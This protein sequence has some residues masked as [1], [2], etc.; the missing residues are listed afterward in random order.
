MKNLSFLNRSTLIYLFSST[1][2]FNISKAQLGVSSGSVSHTVSNGLSSANESGFLNENTIIVEDFMNYHKHQ[3]KIPKKNEVA[4]SIDYDNTIL[5]SDD[6]F[7]LQ[8]GLA[9]QNVSARE[10]SNKANVSLVI[11]NSGSM[12]GGKLEKV[13]TALKVF[14][15]GLKPEDLIS[16]VKFDDTANLVL[17]SSKIKDV[18][19][20]LDAIIESIYPSGSTNI[21]SGMMMGYSEA[22]KH[23]TKDY[24]SKVILLT[25]GMTNSGITDPETILKQSKEFNDKG[26]DIST[27]G[28]GQQLDFDLLRRIAT[29][30]RGSNYFI[31]DVEEDIQKTFK[32]ELESLLYNIGKKPK[33]TI[34]LPEG[35][36]IKTFYGYQPKYI[37][38]HE[39][40]VELENL[41][42]GQ[43]QIFLME[44]EKN[45][46]ENSSIT[47]SLV[48]EK[49]DEVK[50][51]SSKKEYDEMTETTQ[52]ELKKN[53]QIAK[54]TT[55]LKK[56][57][58]DFSQTNMGN[59]KKSMQ[60]IISYYQS[61]CDKNDEDLKRIYNI[62]LK[63][64]SGKNTRSYY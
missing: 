25:D 39:I 4:L 57:A 12:G 42:C 14:V 53:F 8:I 44:V 54:M 21:H 64:S 23:N 35:M 37:S 13:K 58:K 56:A 47:A 7:L 45:E 3:I 6:N 24:N 10:N 63:Y 55:A 26:I 41:D 27:I 9:T 40:E 33:L 59:S 31:G 52:Q 38:D 20:N 36:N 18:A 60:N 50:N 19:G 32:D 29:Y 48:Y 30:G 15:K 46:L 61:F 22:Q 16:I 51:I 28:V 62:A 5:N 49:N 2:L 1:F 17:K 43:T 34:N 11:D